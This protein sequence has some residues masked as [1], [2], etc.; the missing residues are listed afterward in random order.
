MIDARPAGGGSAVS[1]DDWQGFSARF[2][3][4]GSRDM[5]H[6]IRQGLDVRE[7]TRLN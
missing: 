3:R 6:V 7:A 5:A 4:F 2:V 1:M